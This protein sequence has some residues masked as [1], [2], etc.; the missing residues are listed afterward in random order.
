MSVSNDFARQVRECTERL[1]AVGVGAL[2]SL[3]DL[4]AQRLVRFAAALT[5]HQHDAEDAVQTTLVR[6]AGQPQFLAKADCPWAYLLRMVRNEALLITRRKQ[7]SMNAGEVSDLLTHCPVDEAE[8]A[9]SHQA[10]WAALRTLPSEQAEVVVLKIWEGLTFAQI[11]DVLTISPNTAA[12]RYQYAM[13]KL[14]SRLSKSGQPK[15]SQPHTCQL[16]SSTM[17]REVSYD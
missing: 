13:V 15:S 1:S 5:R 11:G 6:L 16:S 9:E 3:F 4:T 2:G 8:R 12:S 14:T 7:R 17:P 10:V